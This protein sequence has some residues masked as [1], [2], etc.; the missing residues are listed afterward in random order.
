MSTR[1]KSIDFLVTGTALTVSVVLS[2]PVLRNF[3]PVWSPFVYA[4]I[5][6]FAVMTFR[7]IKPVRWILVKPVKL[8]FKTLF[9]PI[10]RYMAHLR[11]DKLEALFQ[12]SRVRDRKIRKYLENVAKNYWRLEERFEL[13]RDRQDRLIAL[14]EAEPPFE[15]LDKVNQAKAVATPGVL[16]DPALETAVANAD[17]PLQNAVNPDANWTQPTASILSSDGADFEADQKDIA[18]LLRRRGRDRSDEERNERRS[19]IDRMLRRINAFGRRLNSRAETILKN[20]AKM[21]VPSSHDD[22]H[23]TWTDGTKTLA[24]A[25]AEFQKG[26]R[27]INNQTSNGKRRPRLDDLRQFIEPNRLLEQGELKLEEAAV[28]QRSWSGFA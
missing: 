11:K 9:W 6:M 19:E 4:V 3:D 27:Y 7:R 16:F 8:V 22:F 10:T 28:D 24:K 1:D 20:A 13:I 25:G 21:D 15:S 23:R 17:R 14:L 2:L 5:W 18:E 12:V 26:V